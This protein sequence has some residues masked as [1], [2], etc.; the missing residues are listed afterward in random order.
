[1]AVFAVA[2]R[3]CYRL[4]DSTQHFQGRGRHR[5]VEP[6]V[7]AANHRYLSPITANLPASFP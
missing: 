5:P 4:K 7:T 3:I 1:M 2:V 6:L